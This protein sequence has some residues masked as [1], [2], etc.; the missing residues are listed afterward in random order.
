MF[1]NQNQKSQYIKDS[2]YNNH[3]KLSDI[4]TLEN[5][6]H[7]YPDNEIKTKSA[8]LKAPSVLIKFLKTA[9]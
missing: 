7:D 8:I 1:Y 3:Y 9:G 4:I 2:S 5:T 6:Y